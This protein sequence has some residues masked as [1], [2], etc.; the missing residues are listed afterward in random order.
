MPH[1]GKAAGAI[2]QGSLHLGGVHI[3]QGGYVD[4]SAVAHAL[5]HAGPYIHGAEQVRVAHKVSL[6]AAEQ[7]DNVVDQACA[8]GEDVLHGAH[9]HNGGD[10]VG[11]VSDHLHHF[12]IGLALQLVDRQRQNDGHGKGDDQVV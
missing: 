10:E 7:G 4:D 5:P 8:G 3:G 12:L 6:G 11:Q 1:A 9:Q 2:H